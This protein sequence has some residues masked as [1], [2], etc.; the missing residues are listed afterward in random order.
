MERIKDTLRK[1]SLKRKY[2]IMLFDLEISND[3][4]AWIIEKYDCSRAEV[5]KKVGKIEFDLLEFFSKKEIQL[6][7]EKIKSKL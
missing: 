5:I 3:S 6:I 2:E 7:A 1:N 4:S